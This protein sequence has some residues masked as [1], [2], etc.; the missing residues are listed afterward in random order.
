MARSSTKPGTDQTVPR[1]RF[2]AAWTVRSVPGA[3]AR[4]AVFRFQRAPIVPP[5]TGRPREYEDSDG[6]PEHPQGMLAQRCEKALRVRQ[7]EIVHAGEPDGRKQ[8]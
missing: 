4:A 2:C 6:S 3:H 1:R 8:P 7:E 5:E